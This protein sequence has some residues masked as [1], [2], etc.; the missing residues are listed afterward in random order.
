[1]SPTAK[2]LEQIA[3][4]HQQA[5]HYLNHAPHP[6]L[7][8]LAIGFY[9][10]ALK[11]I[12]NHFNTLFALAKVWHRFGH[13]DKALAYCKQALSVE[14]DSVHARF[15]HCTLQIA[16]LEQTVQEGDLRW[17]A[18]EQ[19][20]RALNQWLDSADFQTLSQAITVL[21]TVCPHFV[22]CKGKAELTVQ[23]LWGKAVSKVLSAIESS[24]H[25]AQTLPP[26]TANERIRV[27]I[28]SENFRLHSDWKMLLYGWMSQL[29]SKRFALFGYHLGDQKDEATA[30]ARALCTRFVQGP[31]TFDQWQKEIA[32][33]RPHV[34]I[35][36]EIG[37]HK[38]TTPLAGLRLAPVQC[39]SW[40]HPLTSG[41]PTV[42]YFLSSELAEAENSDAYYTEKLVRLPFLSTHFQPLT[43]EIPELGRDEFGLRSGA[44]VYLCVQAIVKYQPQYDEVLARIAQGV[45]DSQFVFILRHWPDPL[46]KRFE[47][48][49]QRV[50]VA[51]GLDYARHVVI[52]PRQTPSRYHALARSA[53]IYLDSFHYS[54]GTSTMETAVGHALPAVTLPGQFMRGRQSYA[55]LQGLN[56]TETI[57]A[58]VDDYVALATKL[59][60]DPLWRAS[61][62][63]QM[64]ENQSLVYGDQRCVRGLEQF[65]GEAVE[66]TLT[67]LT[68]KAWPAGV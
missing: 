68:P 38:L 63:R 10:K 31:N 40:G 65:L 27:G 50:F 1:M 66:R 60:L 46:V 64:R 2:H 24:P 42:D 13:T 9:E 52:L 26:L 67:G 51:Y 56:M 7:Q 55:I 58:S 11:L 34:L 57:A 17:E 39:T 43:H 6:K 59:G 20:L 30:T 23:S 29:D 36:P 32:A 18:Y 4:Y 5:K 62:A 14:P 12:P 47:A 33:D 28:V 22:S 25:D 48:R 37:L 44:V 19:H 61:I 45:E 49:L 54:G 3:G 21:Q 35:Y 8:T 41:L 16:I 53:D 15:L